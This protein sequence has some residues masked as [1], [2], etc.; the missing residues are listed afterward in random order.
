MIDTTKLKNLV[1]LRGKQQAQCPVCA[2]A[3]ADS[4]G[5]HLVIYPD[6]AYG[7]VANPGDE[8]HRKQIH[9][10][11]GSASAPVGYPPMTIKRTVVP[12]SSVVMTLGRFGRNIST[13]ERKTDNPT[14][15]NISSE[16]ENTRPKRPS[17]T[18]E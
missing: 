1:S 9:K 3:G 14:T 8:P 16:P 7:C 4:K 18:Q 15:S 12:E 5:E 11:V 2:A 6:G 17:A 10:L 13:P